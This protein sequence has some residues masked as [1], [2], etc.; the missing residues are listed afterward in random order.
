MQSRHAALENE[1]LLTVTVTDLHRLCYTGV[2]YLFK[3]NA[4]T[5]A[6][7]LIFCRALGVC[8]GSSCHHTKGRLSRVC[9]LVFFVF[10]T[11]D[12]VAFIILCH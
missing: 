5:A 11:V 10:V 3:C 12:I 9:L 4:H 1:L 6:F 2:S 8:D 7:M